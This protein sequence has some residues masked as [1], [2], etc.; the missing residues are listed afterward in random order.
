MPGKCNDLLSH[1]LADGSLTHSRLCGFKISLLD[2]ILASLSCELSIFL[3]SLLIFSFG[4]ALLVYGVLISPGLACHHGCGAGRSVGPG[5]ERL[6][7]E[8]PPD[9]VR[10]GRRHWMPAG[11]FSPLSSPL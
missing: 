11:L 3:P 1:E 6:Q 2:L 7:A 4:I 9:L 8:R 5:E 10:L